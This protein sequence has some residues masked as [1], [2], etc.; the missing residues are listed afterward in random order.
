MDLLP[1]RLAEPHRG[2]L[3]GCEV[4]SV[5]VRPDEEVEEEE[6]DKRVDKRV[7]DLI[8]LALNRAATD[9]G[10]EEEEDGDERDSSATLGEA[11][12]FSPEDGEDLSAEPGDTA[13]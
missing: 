13:T 4:R 11:A 1:A 10:G 9:E 7:R 2:H 8:L 5:V 6:I 12:H 3:R